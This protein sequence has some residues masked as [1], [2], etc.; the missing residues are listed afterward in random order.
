MDSKINQVIKL[1]DGNKYVILKQAIYKND[2]YY[3]ASK[4]DLYNNPLAD[5][6]FFFHQIEMDGQLKLEEVTNQELM[7]Y[8]YNYMKIWG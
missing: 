8:L 5:E 6:I 1:D 4:L 2:N 7:K 3:I